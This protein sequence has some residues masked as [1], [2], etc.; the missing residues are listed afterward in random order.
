[1]KTE[2]TWWGYLHVSGTLQVKRYFDKKDIEE[3][4]ESP[5]CAIVIGP[6]L[7]NDRDG[8]LVILKNKLE[9]I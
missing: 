2:N 9:Q 4:K 8:A 6:F 3:A 7:A 1:M 5:Y